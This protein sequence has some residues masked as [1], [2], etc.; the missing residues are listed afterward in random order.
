MDPRH[1]PSTSQSSDAT[2]SNDL[3]D[4]CHLAM[5]QALEIQ[6]RSLD[7]VARWNS[8]LLDSFWFLPDFDKLQEAAAQAFACYTELQMNWLALLTPRALT[9]IAAPS[10]EVLERSMDI[11][12]G[13]CFPALGGRASISGDQALPEEELSEDDEAVAAQAA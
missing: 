11:A 6:K 7:T 2:V 13:V 10:V 1:M 12:M 4:L 3:Q 9:Y 5:C 8:C